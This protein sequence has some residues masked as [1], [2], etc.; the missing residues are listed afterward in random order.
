MRDLLSRLALVACLAV[1]TFISA[2]YVSAASQNTSAASDATAPP[3]AAEQQ[4]KLTEKDLT[5]F[6]AAAKAIEPLLAHLPE[7]R[8]D[9]PDKRTLAALDEA[10]Q[11]A[12]LK[13]YADYN[14]LSS[15]IGFILQGFD[16]DKRTFVGHKAVLEAEIAEVTAD[17]SM[18]KHDR[19][20]ALKELKGDLANVEPVQNPENITLVTKHFDE[21]SA[22]MNP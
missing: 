20:E 4:R 5:S 10:A 19:T 18:S 13:D 17:R 14:E 22:L 1:P 9:D 3:D 6:I 15:N 2:T 11:R 21:L 7:N 8:R 12:S 16:P